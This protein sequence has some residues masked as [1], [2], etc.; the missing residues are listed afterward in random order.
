MR[1]KKILPSVKL[2]PFVKNYW[3]LDV[4]DRDIPFSQVLFPFGS[5][6]L[7]F[8]LVNAPEMQIEGFK[9]AIMQTDSLFP[10]QFTKPF[11]LNYTMPFSAVGISLQPWAGNLLFKTPAQHFTNCLTDLNDLDNKLELRDQLLSAKCEHEIILLFENYILEK[12]KHYQ[13]DL[14][15]TDIANAILKNPSVDEYKDIV[16]TIGFTRRRIEQRFIET[17]G[18]PMGSFVRKIRFQKAVTILRHNKPLTLTQFALEA[19]YYDQ[20][21]FIRDFKEL[22]SLTPKEFVKQNSITN[23][24]ISD[25]MMA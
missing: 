3:L 24:N 25:W 6:E 10:G 20:S 7:I 21:H 23:S 5:F 1:F 22:S 18:L 19:G 8:N 2:Q 9:N 16:S 14:I 17:T 12:L 4:D 15:S 11:L 13:V